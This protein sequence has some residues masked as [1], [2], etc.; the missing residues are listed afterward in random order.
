MPQLSK[1]DCAKV[2]SKASGELISETQAKQLLGEIDRRLK[3]KEDASFLR[4]E[5]K[6]R[7]L[8]DEIIRENKLANALQ[9]RNAILTKRAMRRMKSFAKQHETLADGIDAFMNGGKQLI[10]GNRLSVD[11]Q[12]QALT[13]EYVGQLAAELERIDAVRDFRKGR[14][15][16]EIFNELWNI[17]QGDTNPSGNPTARSIA[18]VIYDV[19]SRALARENRAGGFIREREDYVIRQTHDAGSILGLSPRGPNQ[20]EQS[21]SQWSEEILPLLNH[22]KTFGAMTEK[23]KVDYLRLIYQ[24]IVTGV[25]GRSGNFDPSVEFKGTGALARK[26]S[27]PRLLHFRDADSAYHYNVKFGTR[28]LAEGV[29]QDLRRAG[30]YTAVMENF[31]PNPVQTFD[32]VMREL[33]EEARTLPDG[34]KQI[35]AL[36]SEWLQR[37][38]DGLLGKLDVPHNVTLY[39]V[40]KALQAW[41]TLSKLGGTMI[42]AIPDKAFLHSGMTYNGVRGMDVLR[43]QLGVFVPKTQEDRV[44]IKMM[45][46][47]IDGFLGEVVTRFT[48][49]EPTGGKLFKLQQSMFQINGL[50]WWNDVHKGAAAK[51]LSTWLGENGS[52]AFADIDSDLAKVLN[53]YGFTEREWDIVRSVRRDI[54]E[55]T[56]VLPE[57]VYALPD[58]VWEKYLTDTGGKVTANEVARARDRVTTML[59][60]YIIDQTNDAVV[61]PGNRERVMINMGTRPGTVIGSAV[62][63]IMHFKSFPI[64]VW[65]RVVKRELFG[66]HANTPSVGEW[67]LSEKQ[68]NFRM[69]QLIAMTMVGGYLTM[70]IKDALKGRTPRRVWDDDGYH[71]EV[72]TKAL[73]QGGGLGIYGDLLFTEYDRSYKSVL[74][75]LAGPIVGQAPEVAAMTSDLVRGRDITGAAG[76]FALNNTPYINLFYIRPALDYIILWNLQ[77]MVDPGSLTKMERKVEKE[78]HQGFF[79][80]PSR[81]VR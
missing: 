2:I 80:R 24:G 7:K 41:A 6:V 46:S 56:W 32:R 39:N 31:G 10:P 13:G 17:R 55:Y 50:N 33:R 47:A 60:S 29:I 67:L 68:T 70:S 30:H 57:D 1:R 22:E 36:E 76:K 12:A 45:G 71:H 34:D 21:F 62:R 52:K 16:R 20:Y 48:G 27:N 35:K 15:D 54:G 81:V 26:V 23:G 59:R 65:E 63:L 5:D 61:T 77:E 40:T 74:S 64:S 49:R 72:L 66:R 73:L 19:Q 58:T 9:L 14:I 78:N 43:E 28:T 51:L 42:S 3:E 44:R 75:V 69:L 25:H 53:L 18:R 4:A 8:G 38:F 37:S 79:I 11:A